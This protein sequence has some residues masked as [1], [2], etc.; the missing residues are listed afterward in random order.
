VARLALA[1]AL[2]Q[3][4]SAPVEPNLGLI[5]APQAWALGATGQGVVVAVLDSGADLSHPD[6]AA[7]WRGG[8]NS[9][10]DPY[11]EHPNAPVD[12]S[13]HGTQVLGVI[14]GGEASG[15]H[16]GVAP[17]AQWIAARVFDDRGRA[18]PAAI[19]AVLRWVLDPDG[20]P[21]TDDAP[22]VVNASWSSTRIECEAE[23]A[24]DLQAL[25]DAG[26]L[27][28]FAGGAQAPMSPA[29]L[30][31]AVAVGALAEAN[32]LAEDSP[33][34]PSPCSDAS[35]VF[36]QL[37]APGVNIHTTDLFGLYASGDGTSLAAAH[38][39][40]A[41]A[42]VLSVKPGLSAD[43]Q[44]ALLRRTAV[45]LGGPGPD[46]AFG[47]GRLH[48]GAAVARVRSPG[49]LPVVLLAVI[50]STMSVVWLAIKRGGGR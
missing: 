38:V 11:G 27:P 20:D 39:S 28:V 9:W 12:F 42:L 50:V 40:G 14:V 13:G 33:R 5:G 8:D 10:F 21:L 32:T 41:L 31:A 16:I 19:H 48:V 15:R 24:P 2:V 36:P 6:L 26:I 43:E 22:D 3:T 44:A 1:G 34:G 37:V 7:R 45:D 23:F 25:R 29:N 4:T 46:N 17:D 49:A 47:Y 35:E 18:T 30:P